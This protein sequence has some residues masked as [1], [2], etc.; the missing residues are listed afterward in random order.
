MRARWSASAR[1]RAFTSARAT[2]SCCASRAAREGQKRDGA[3]RARTAGGGRS[4]MMFGPSDSRVEAQ[5]RSRC[6]G[7]SSASRT[8]SCA[9]SSST[10]P[11]RRR[12]FLGLTMPDPGVA[13]GRSRAALPLR[14]RSTGANSSRCCRGNGP[15]NRER[16]E[17]R[18]TRARRRRA[19][20]ATPRWP[21]P[22]SRH[23]SAA[24]GLKQDGDIDVNIR[25][26][27]P[28]YEIFIRA[29]SGLD[30][31]HVGSLHATDARMA[32]EHA[33]DV[34]TRRQEGVSIWVVR[35]TTSSRPIRP[36][37][38]RCSSRRATRSTGTRR[39]TRS[40]TRS[41]TL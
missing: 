32:I 37:P 40:R 31:K 39:S 18:R 21:T 10:P 15:C 5:R 23:A 22:R 38:T 34:Y 41:K 2:K 25:Q 16:L 13:L 1:K 6:A 29:K 26:D 14:R 35:S 8:T 28:L 30:H 20:C 12:E 19:G 7:R 24:G 17:A 9:R 3:G 27:W 33:R 4:L 11:C 36:T